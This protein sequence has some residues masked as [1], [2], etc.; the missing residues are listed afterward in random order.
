LEQRQIVK[1]FREISALHDF[2]AEPSLQALY[3]DH[4]KIKGLS[5]P[6]LIQ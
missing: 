3:S 1:V 5:N 4:L 6:A 2:T